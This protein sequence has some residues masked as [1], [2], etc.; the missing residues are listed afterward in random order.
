MIQFE[1][2]PEDKSIPEW[3][4]S[5]KPREAV[6]TFEQMLS[7]PEDTQRMVLQDILKH[8]E[9]SK[10]GQ[11]YHFSDLHSA[12]DYCKAV[13]VTEY[14][15]YKEMIPELLEGAKDV[16]Y[17]GE[18]VM[19]L[20]TSGSTGIPK[21]I[22]ESRHGSLAKNLVV[23]LRSTYTFQMIKDL[24]FPGA[25]I[26]AIYNPAEYEKTKSGI[27][28]GSASGQAS[29]DSD[30]QDLYVLPPEFMKL[31][32]LSSEDRDYVTIL[33]AAATRDIV[34]VVCNNPGHFEI[35]IKRLNQN[36]E[37]LAADLRAGTISVEM[38][39]AIRKKL[40]ARLGKHT[41]RAKELLELFEMKYEIMVKDLWP[42]L[43]AMSCWTSGSVGRALSDTKKILPED[44][45]FIDWGYG[46]SEGKFNIPKEI[47]TPAGAAASFGYFFEFRPLDG[48]KP[49]YLW[50]TEDDKEYELIVTSY[51]GFY[52]YNIHDIVKIDGKNTNTPRMVFQCKRSDCM[53][54]TGKVLLSN[55]LTSLIENYEERFHTV[56]R[57]FELYAPGCGTAILAAEPAEELDTASFAYEIRS[58]LKNRYGITVDEIWIMKDG[59]RDSLYSRNV[60]NGK[61]VNQ[62]KLVVFTD[63]MPDQSYRTVVY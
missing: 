35:L 3:M 16:L 23:S 50:E 11:K 38:D 47:N 12:E 27:P 33:F 54:Q 59:Y 51:S 17:D 53:E 44:T 57:H 37:R 63:K 42:R 61:S 8:A 22:P 4:S 48:S 18:T 7:V 1:Q 29:A 55:Q 24:L 49:L 34:G 43:K 19:F 9:H 30:G 36:V 28:I 56:I 20:A 32:D 52:R 62:T 14:E 39:E 31:S 6:I 13:P 45:V 40:E 41:E 46:A 5:M 2:R 26:F 21:Y 25:K 10:W 58:G 60:K 15:H